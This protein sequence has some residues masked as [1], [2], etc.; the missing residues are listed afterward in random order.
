[1]MDEI[2]EI[3]MIVFAK[4]KDKELNTQKQEAVIMIKMLFD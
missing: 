1:M 3:V 4:D 2:T